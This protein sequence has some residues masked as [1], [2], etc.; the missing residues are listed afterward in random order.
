MDFNGDNITGLL[1]D[2]DSDGLVDGS[3]NY[4]L[5]NSGAAIDLTDRRGRKF[6]DASTSSWDVVKA[7]PSGSGF[8]VL[9]DGAADKENK[10]YVWSTNDSGVMTTGSGWKTGNQMMQLGYEDIFGCNMNDNPGIGI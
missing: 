6:S 5:F 3:S 2:S 10:F 7:V 9:L 8:Q 1:S 4:Q